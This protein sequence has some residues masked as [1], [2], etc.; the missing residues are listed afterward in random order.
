MEPNEKS[1]KEAMVTAGSIIDFKTIDFYHHVLPHYINR[2]ILCEMTGQTQRT[3]Q[4][5]A[6]KVISSYELN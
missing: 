1:V 3:T 6:S 4:K 5:L 2:R